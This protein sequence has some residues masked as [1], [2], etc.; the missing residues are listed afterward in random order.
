MRTIQFLGFTFTLA[1][2][3][4]GYLLL[5]PVDSETTESATSGV[6]FGL[7][8]IVVPL[9]G[10]SALLLIPSSIAL[11]ST[12]VRSAS[13]FYGKFWF[14]LWGANSLISLSYILAMGYLTY[15][16]AMAVENT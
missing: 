8:L 15:V 9:L 10:C 6:G 5:A 1:G 3:I 14:G 4:L 7:M 16:Y 13:Y 2:L 11:I 12:R